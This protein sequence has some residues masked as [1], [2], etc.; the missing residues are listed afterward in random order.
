[1]DSVRVMLSVVFIN[2]VSWWCSF[3]K[4]CLT[5]CDPVDYST[6]GLPVLHYLPEF[7][8]IYVQ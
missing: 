6:P 1:M 7:A 5:F 8:Q 3:T 4:S 2:L